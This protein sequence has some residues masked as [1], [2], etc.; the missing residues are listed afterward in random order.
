[1]S[2]DLEA[3]AGHLLALSEDGVLGHDLYAGSIFLRN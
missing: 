3:A 1:M 2:N